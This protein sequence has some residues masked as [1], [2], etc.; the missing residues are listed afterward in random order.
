MQSNTVVYC[1]NEPI[2]YSV[3]VIKVDRQIHPHQSHTS[4][5]VRSMWLRTGLSAGWPSVLNFS[6]L[7]LPIVHFI[8]GTIKTYP[9]AMFSSSDYSLVVVNDLMCTCP[10]HSTPLHYTTLNYTTLHYTTLTAMI[11]T[12]TVHALF[13]CSHYR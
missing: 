4:I 13:S 6:M 11:S 2:S 5:K 1:Q 8:I 9:L 10:L 7:E 12:T 3:D